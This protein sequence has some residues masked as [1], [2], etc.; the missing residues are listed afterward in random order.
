MINCTMIKESYLLKHESRQSKVERRGWDP[1]SPSHR[2]A[3]EDSNNQSPSTHR[4]AR[5]TAD[6]QDRQKL[7]T[8]KQP[9]DDCS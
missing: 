9:K 5:V 3:R 7:P 1:G 6:V 2:C 8:I 4:E